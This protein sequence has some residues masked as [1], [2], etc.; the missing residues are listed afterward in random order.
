VKLSGSYQGASS[1]APQPQRQATGF[2]RGPEL[3]PNG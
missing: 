2:S 3:L 1:D